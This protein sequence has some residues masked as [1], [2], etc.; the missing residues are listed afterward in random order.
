MTFYLLLVL[1]VALYL[2]CG[3]LLLSWLDNSLWRSVSV[4]VE[5][6]IPLQLAGWVLWPVTMLV[7]WS[8]HAWRRHQYRQARRRAPEKPKS[9][10][11]IGGYRR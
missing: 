9:H 4:L 6:A 11:R 10:V 8:A 2:G 7:A 5:R 3:L 1:A